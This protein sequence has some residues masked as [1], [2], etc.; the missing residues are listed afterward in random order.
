MSVEGIIQ[1]RQD[2]LAFSV[3]S[4]LWVVRL[5]MRT[6]RSWRR[7]GDL[8]VL[9]G[10]FLKDGYHRQASKKARNWP[11]K[12]NDQPPGAPKIRAA[13][14]DEIRWTCKTYEAA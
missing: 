12:K 5:A 8:R 6:P 1:Q 7:R 3:A 11:H 14:S 4:S 13:T 9:L 10:R 2:P